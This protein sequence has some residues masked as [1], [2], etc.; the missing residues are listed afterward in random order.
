MWVFL[1]VPIGEWVQ[2][3]GRKRV[4]EKVKRHS[5]KSVR[6]YMEIDGY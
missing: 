5:V 2:A 4:Y 6:V 1:R 3:V